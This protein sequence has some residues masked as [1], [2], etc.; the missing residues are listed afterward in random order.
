MAGTKGLARLPQTTLQLKKGDRIGFTR[1]ERGNLLAVAGTGTA[2]LEPVPVGVRYLAWYY[3]KDQP[4]FEVGRAV[5]DSAG[6]VGGVAA[7][8]ALVAGAATVNAAVADHEDDDRGSEP[9]QKRMPE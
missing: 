3:R 9:W 7:G 8:A 5:R 6:R 2:G 1:D 4:L